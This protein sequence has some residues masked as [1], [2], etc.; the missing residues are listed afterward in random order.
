MLVLDEYNN[1][2]ILAP[3]FQRII[4]AIKSRIPIGSSSL[5]YNPQIHENE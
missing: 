2:C 3:L 5:R 1:N 4:G